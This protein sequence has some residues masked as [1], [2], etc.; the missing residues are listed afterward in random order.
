MSVNGEKK[1]Q[2]T[3]RMN[4]RYWDEK[5]ETVRQEASAKRTPKDDAPRVHIQGPSTPF[6]GALPPT[7]E[8]DAWAR[9]MQLRNAARTEPSRE[10]G[11]LPGDVPENEESIRQED[12]LG[13]YSTPAKGSAKHFLAF[14]PKTPI[15]RTALTTGGAVAIGLL[16]GFLVLSVFTQKEFS[17]SYGSVLSDTVQTLTAQEAKNGQTGGQETVAGKGTSATGAGAEA[18][19][20]NA[21]SGEQHNVS[22]QVPQI[23]MFV[24]QTGVFQPDA[25]PESAA[26]PLAKAGIPHLFYKDG[27]KQYMF[28][29]AAPTRDA[30]LGFAA[31]LKNKGMDVYVKEFAFPAFQGAVPVSKPAAATEG[32]NVQEFFDNGVKLARALSAQSG[33][34]ITSGQLSS[35]MQETADLKEWHRQLLEESRLIQVQEAWKPL[36]EGM[37][38]GINQAMAARDKMAEASA[39]KKGDSA[40]SY[41]WQVQA[42]V[43]RYLENY[44]SWVQMAR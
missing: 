1:N 19:A 35:S 29:A 6:H 16:F 32:P 24:A 17:Q 20:G 11:L 3:V 12:F 38:N 2:V 5:R 22:L 33:L 27:G 39:G 9:M 41:A 43:L 40:E 23:S 14:W 34:I 26:E 18:A 31:S 25:S 37:V 21:F 44:A 7:K 10:A 13:G 8:N 30:V 42:G 4:G 28:A 36:F 15:W